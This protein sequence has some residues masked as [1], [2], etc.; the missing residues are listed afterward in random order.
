MTSDA[1]T[2]TRRGVLAGASGALA[3]TLTPALARGALVPGVVLYAPRSEPSR[4]FAEVLAARGA[5]A[6]AL[7]GD[8]VRQWHDGLR[9]TVAGNGGELAGITPWSDY[10][11]ARGLAAELRRHVRFEARHD[12]GRNG[13]SHCLPARYCAPVQSGAADRWPERLAQVLLEV[14]RTA[15]LDP[16]TTTIGPSANGRGAV[17]CFSWLIA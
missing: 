4:R 12:L 13:V 6:V 3:L 14:D 11:V 5:L 16:V 9:T 7:T 1:H 17:S 10:V 2:I 8:L 15:P